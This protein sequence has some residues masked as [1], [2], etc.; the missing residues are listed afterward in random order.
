MPESTLISGDDQDIVALPIVQPLAKRAAQNSFYQRLVAEGLDEQAAAAVARA[1]VDPTDARRRLDRLVHVRVPGGR[2]LVL[3]TVLWAPALAPYAVNNREASGRHYPAGGFDPDDE[4]SRFRP[5]RPAVDPDDGSARLELRAQS[6]EHLVW[7]LERSAKYLIDHNSLAESI[8]AQGVMVSVTVV[9]V[10]CK[11]GDQSPP[12]TM[13]GTADGSSRTTGAH[14]VLELTPDDVL[15]SLPEDDRSYR[16]M[17]AELLAALDRPDARVSED[18]IRKL[19]ALQI[20]ARLLLRY[21]PDDVQPVDFAKAVESLVHLVHVEPPKEWDEAA[22]LDAKADSVLHALKTSGVV[23][24]RR[25]AYL[26]GMLTP[27]EARGFG[28]PASAD[29]RALEL[30]TT[31]SSD[32]AAN[33]RAVRDGVLELSHAQKQVRKDEKARIAVEL[34]LR[35]IRAEFPAASMKSARLALASAYQAPAIWG[36]EIAGKADETPEQLRDAALAELD[37]GE[38]GRVCARLAGQGAFW[39]AGYRILR[40]AHFFVEKDKRDGR[41]PQRVLEAL[42]CSPYGIRVLH[43]AII[44]GRDGQPPVQIDIDGKR[45]KTVAGKTIEMTHE[46][47]RRTVV[48]PQGAP[49]TAPGGKVGDKTELPTR[50]LIGRINRLRDAVDG[51]VDAHQQL[52]EVKDAAGNVLVDRSGINK[53]RAEE[54][55]EHL[56]KIRTRLA[57][58]AMTWSAANDEDADD[59]LYADEDG[60][61][62]LDQEIDEIDSELAGEGES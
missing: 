56:E 5:L 26:D 38:P 15:F 39:L 40:D 58:Y 4:A 14:Q 18:E 36:K 48:P 33:K 55:R 35:A 31:I 60:H 42:M 61:S 8:A 53:Q 43:R 28:L 51:V 22:A 1:V 57:M 37:D 11:F 62:D 3:D 7:S 2:F 19:R 25:K 30:V 17:L 6:P 23:T 13:L 49:T 29:Q 27:E 52:R 47:L 54:L 44:D 12:V 50:M 46:W 45:D 16:G 24:M 41:S 10:T 21:E 9:V 59:D 32:K 34:G 20:P